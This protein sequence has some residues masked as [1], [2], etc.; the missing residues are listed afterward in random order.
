MSKTNREGYELAVLFSRF[1][2]KYDLAKLRQTNQN[3]LDELN[4]L[5]RKKNKPTLKTK[6]T[7]FCLG[8]NTTLGAWLLFLLFL[9]L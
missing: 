5:K 7:W 2:Y 1:S 3:L 8:A 6:G 9:V 4:S